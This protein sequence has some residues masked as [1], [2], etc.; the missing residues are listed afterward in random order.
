MKKILIFLLI[1]VTVLFVFLGGVES[2]NITVFSVSCSIEEDLTNK[3]E[4]KLNMFDFSSLDESLKN[5]ESNK[6]FGA[7]T[8]LEKVKQLINGEYSGDFGGLM[9]SVLN[10]FVADFKKLIPLLASILAL[11]LLSNLLGQF[12][13]NSNKNLGE[14]VHFVCYIAIIIII[15]T[16]ITSLIDLT[17]NTISSMQTQMEIIFPII[18]TLMASVGSTV[19]VGIY[20]PILAMLSGLIVNI[21]SY[22]VLPIFIISFVISIVGNLS[23]NVKL[24]KFSSLLNDVFKWVIGVVFTV[25]T[26]IMTIRGISAGSFDSVSIRTTK[27]AIKNYVP[28]VGG[29]LSDGFNVLMASS[30]LIK[31]AVGTAGLFLVFISIL[32]PIITI[33]IFKWALHLLSAF[34][35]PLFDSKISNFLYSVSKAIN[36]LIA[37]ILCVALMYII[38]MGLLMTTGNA[39]WG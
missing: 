18:L 21:F 32:S 13:T 27:F 15:C 5:L 38:S 6:E 23:S 36:M 4:E 31:N 25:F 11:A 3:T 30:V 24:N 39:Y 9:K 28:I 37:T 1:F 8:F 26:G 33:L 20:Q 2:K 16:S 7:S 12:K 22:V 14:I 29:Y 10:I 35:E 34:L 19:S 17:Q